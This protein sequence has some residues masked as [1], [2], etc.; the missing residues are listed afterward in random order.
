MIIYRYY[1]A[2]CFLIFIL[3]IDSLHAGRSK[4]KI[5]SQAPDFTLCDEHGTAHTLSAL[6]GHKIALIFYPLDPTSLL[7]S[8]HCTAELC[9]IRDGFADL[10]SAGVTVLGINPGSIESH[11]KF[12]A[13]HKFPFPLLSDNDKKVAK[14]YGAKRFLGPIKRIT[15]L[16]DQKGTVVAI[17][18]N[19]NVAG[20]AQEI[21]QAFQS[22]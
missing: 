6:R 19:V 16:I 4:L 8:P 17:I 20:H 18:H 1:A 11:K 21:I 5:G 14:A 10:Q 2:L 13:E 12:K 7:P 15:V 22:V 9:S 3:L